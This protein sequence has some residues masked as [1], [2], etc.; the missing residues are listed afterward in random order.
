MN[1]R[2]RNFRRTPAQAENPILR[3][4]RQQA[5]NFGADETGCPCKDVIHGTK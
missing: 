4:F 5:Q 1:R 3:V 2:T